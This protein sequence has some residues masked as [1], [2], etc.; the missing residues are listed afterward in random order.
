MLFGSTSLDGQYNNSMGGTALF[1]LAK[2]S[3]QNIIFPFVTQIVMWLKIGV[4]LYV[5]CSTDAKWFG[6]RYWKPSLESVFAAC[7]CCNHIFIP[8]WLSSRVCPHETHNPFW[9]FNYCIRKRDRKSI[10]F[11]CFCL[12]NAE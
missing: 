4:I 12:C 8:V 7:T 9:F 2:A 11:V 3:Y 6:Q 1:L 10:Y 5:A